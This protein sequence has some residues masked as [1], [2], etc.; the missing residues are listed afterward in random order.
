MV[1]DHSGCA[2][3]VTEIVRV[4]MR[5]DLLS[6][7]LV[8]KYASISGIDIPTGNNIRVI[9]KFRMFAAEY[10]LSGDGPINLQL[11]RRNKYSE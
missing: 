11:M 10:D 5:Q 8:L 9:G 6:H 4:L 7:G 1:N 2:I 3:D